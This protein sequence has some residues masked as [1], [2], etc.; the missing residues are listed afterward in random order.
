MVTDRRAYF[1]EYYKRPDIRQRRIEYYKIWRIKNK[2]K[3]KD[4][5]QR[6]HQRVKLKVLALVGKGEIK[7][8]KCGHNDIRIL[9]VNHKSGGGHKEITSF[10][11]NAQMY[12]NIAKG[13]RITSDLSILC[14]VCNAA[15]FVERKFG[16]KFKITPTSD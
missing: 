8:N 15:D 16:I 12:R 10:K 3:V 11:S 7:C 13:K 6:R 4:Y 5:H 9:E 14:R 2:H 1:R